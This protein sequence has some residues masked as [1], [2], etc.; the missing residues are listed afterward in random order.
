M[1]AAIEAS[2]EGDGFHVARELTGHGIGREMHEPPTV[3]NWP[4]PFDEASER[5]S[6]GLVFTI[7]PMITT[8]EPRFAAASDGWTIRSLDR[9]RSTHEEHTLMVRHG[10]ALV[11]TGA[12]E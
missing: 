3:F 11:L 9:A 1:G 2:V 6:E 7:E 12:A 5:L 8:G 4:A 10:G